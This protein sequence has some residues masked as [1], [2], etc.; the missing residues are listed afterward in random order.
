MDIDF[1]SPALQ[2]STFGAPV[3]IA[4]GPDFLANWADFPSVFVSSTG[5]I[6]AHWLQ[7]GVGKPYGI[8]VR[9]S[10][11]GGKTWTAPKAPHQDSTAGEY[12]FVSFFEAP[13]KGLGLI[14]LDGRAMANPGGIQ[15]GRSHGPAWRFARRR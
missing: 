11:D 5:T 14:W 8:Q 9:S 1:N 4:E 13:G 12:G 2:G 6:A 15:P 3:T 10:A 7:R